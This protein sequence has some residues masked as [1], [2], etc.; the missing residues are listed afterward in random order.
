MKK[1]FFI[2]TIATSI[3][4]GIISCQNDK[5]DVVYPASG[6][7]GCDTTTVRYSV[8]VQGVL[9][10]YC[11]RCHGGTADAGAGIQLYD[12]GTAS[13]YALDG[14]GINGEGS[15]LSSVLQDGGVEPMPLGGGKIDDCSINIIRA[16]TNA[17]APNN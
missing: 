13:G 9:N 11:Q 14:Y 4:I 7:G 1:L 5:A 17:G 3:S 10:T 15:L 16:W 6:S 8:E 12:Y 2:I